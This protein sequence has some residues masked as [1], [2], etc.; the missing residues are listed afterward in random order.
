MP[1]IYKPKKRREYNDYTKKR[2]KRQ[3]IY[4]TTT[5][6]EMRLAK[7]MRSPLCEICELEG[8]TT[9][10]EDVH[11]ALSFL[12]VPE[13]EMLRVAYDADNLISVCRKCHNR[14]HNGDLQGTK[15]LDEIKER[16]RQNK[17][18]SKSL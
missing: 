7:L 14:C 11:H 2:E 16:I 9:L 3:N 10:A 5:W 6:R 15:S 17:A 12:D 4:N 18:K 1:T 8:K 13:D